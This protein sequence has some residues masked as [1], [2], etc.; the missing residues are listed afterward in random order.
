MRSATKSSRIISTSVSPSTYSEWLRVR[1]RV[2]ALG[3]VVMTLV[4]QHA[5]DLRGECLIEDAQDDRPV[6]F[7]AVCNRSVLNVL[8]GTSA[9]LFDVS[10]ER[11]FLWLRSL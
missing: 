7:V 3:H 2:D 8:T 1:M 4:A 10:Q 9:N 6:A 5:N 11:K